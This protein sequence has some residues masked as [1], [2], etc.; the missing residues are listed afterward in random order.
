[1]HLE[2]SYLFSAFLSAHTFHSLLTSLT[3]KRQVVLCSF[4]IKGDRGKERLSHLSKSVHLVRSGVRSQ[5]WVDGSRIHLLTHCLILNS[6]KFLLKMQ[7]FVVTFSLLFFL[8]SPKNS[9]DKL[10][11]KPLSH[12]CSLKLTTVE[13]NRGAGRRNGSYKSRV[14]FP[15]V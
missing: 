10:C 13:S 8:F 2:V 1:M 11:K 14:F 6:L 7:Y 5:T 12:E 4:Y 9:R 3:T 15:F